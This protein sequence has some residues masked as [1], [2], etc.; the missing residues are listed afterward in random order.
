MRITSRGLIA[1]AGARPPKRG[2]ASCL[3]LW[4]TNPVQPNAA[5]AESSGHG[6]ADLH[7]AY[8]L[9][10][11]GGSGQT[12]PIVDAQVDPNAESDLATYCS[13][14]HL[15]ACTTANGC[16]SKVNE[17]R[18]AWPLPLCKAGP[19]WDGPTGLGTP[20]GTGAFTSAA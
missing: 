19:G 6:P 16:F 20:N 4:H 9:P 2:S 11:S 15:S 7:S 10:S 5:A 8:A 12:V 14:Y 18:Q 1:L 17:N 13:T 3:A